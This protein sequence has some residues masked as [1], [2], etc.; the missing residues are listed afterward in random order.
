MIWNVLKPVKWTLAPVALL[1]CWQAQAMTLSEALNRAKDHD[2]LVPYSLALYSADKEQGAQIS[3]NRLPSLS[4]D[5]SYAKNQTE[6][7]SEFFPPVDEDYVSHAYGISARQALYRYDWSALGEH[8][9][10]L[11]E[12]AELGLL[13]RKQKFLIRVAERYFAVLD[14]QEGLRLAKSEA[15]AIAESL[16]DTRRRHEV[17]LV[18]GTDLKEAQARD[19]LAKA[20]LILAQQEL[21]SAKD[22]LDESTGNGYVR[23]PSLPEASDLPP[24]EQKALDAWLEKVVAN[25][26]EL[27]DLRQE[28]VVAEAQAKQAKSGLLPRL[29]AVASYREDDT[30]ESPVG[31]QRN[32]TRIGVELTVPIYQGGI[33]RARNREA[34]A[35]QEAAEANLKRIE[36]E[37]RRQARQ[38]YRELQAAY[39]QANALKLAVT[40]ARAAE[41]A[42]RNGY[43]A[44]TRTITDVLNARSAL[45]SAQRDYASTR[46]QLLLGR[47]QLKQLSAELGLDDFASV[48]RLLRVAENDDEADAT[49]EEEQ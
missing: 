31:S 44:G 6:S 25:N 7:E 5:G 3:G 16:E 22:A 26:P 20:R 29:D 10:A 36:A 48:D 47:M 30:S 17:G 11:D 23:L 43:K 34:L 39:A 46:Y 24:M 18:P 19:D 40:S 2:P 13:D 21:D 38:Q 12:K 42:T 35:R 4:L 14:A 37:V 45:I 32:D 49:A 28:V 9:D 33:Q 27:Q 8:A 15:K 1:G 41:E